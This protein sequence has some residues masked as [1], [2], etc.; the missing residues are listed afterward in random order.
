MPQGKE[1]ETGLGNG[2]LGERGLGG[3][4]ECLRARAGGGMEE[5]EDMPAA[6]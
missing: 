1:T 2:Y 4:D 5:I 3:S 6:A